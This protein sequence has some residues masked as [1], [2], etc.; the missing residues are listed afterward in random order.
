MISSI[1]HTIHVWYIYTFTFTRKINQ[2]QVYIPMYCFELLRTHSF[3]F[4]KG[5]LFL[6]GFWSSF[7][8]CFFRM[9]EQFVVC[10]S[11]DLWLIS[12]WF[13]ARWLGDSN[14]VAWSNHPLHKF[15]QGFQ[16]ESRTTKFL[17]G[18]FFQSNKQMMGFNTTRKLYI[19]YRQ[20]IWS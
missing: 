4:Y 2:M 8:I 20:K 5:I 12:W 6:G 15:S 17:C 18:Y 3:D 13:G 10:L 1:P 11:R 14:R 9:G 16:S 7:W 19:A